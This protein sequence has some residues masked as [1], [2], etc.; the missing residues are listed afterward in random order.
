MRDYNVKSIRQDFKEKGIFYTTKDLAEYLKSF[1]PDDVYEIYDPTC[2]NGGL[3]SV[4]AD[5]VQKYG[6]D[7]NAEQVRDAQERLKNFHGVV[8][9][10]LKAPAFDGKKFKYII[11]N[12]PFSIKWEPKMD[13][14]FEGWPCLP[15]PSKA[16][17]AFLAHILHYLSDD[18][19]AVV[20]NFPGILYR[21]NVE[22]KIRR[23]MVEQNYI[24]TVIA[25]DGGH[26]VDTKIATAVLILKKK[27]TSTDVKFIH[28]DLERIAPVSE[29]EGNDYN[30]SVSSYIVEVVEREKIDPVALE[31]HAREQF[32]SR[33]EK[34]LAFEKMVCDLEGMDIRP[35]V[36]AIQE[37]VR[38]YDEPRKRRIFDES[39]ISMFSA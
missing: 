34:E 33:L 23:W 28:N 1:L 21:G 19:I 35:F 9:D 15:P 37:I 39:Q 8:G 29:I 5:D 20:L 18:G 25:V 2:G 10:T 27:K 14:R 17:Y 13:E 32:L 6:Q 26:F 30:L 11:A 16:D 7:I 12:P 36:R 24:D 4:F 22:G 38:K 3:L 31:L